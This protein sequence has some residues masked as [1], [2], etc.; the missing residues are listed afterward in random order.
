[1]GYNKLSGGELSHLEVMTLTEKFPD[2]TNGVINTHYLMA[3]LAMTIGGATGSLFD[4]IKTVE[5][6]GLLGPG[7]YSWGGMSATSVPTPLFG[8]RK[9]NPAFIN[10]DNLEKTE[11]ARLGI[12]LVIAGLIAGILPVA[13]TLGGGALAVAKVAPAVGAQSAT[14]ALQNAG[15]RNDIDDMLA[16]M[17]PPILPN[18]AKIELALLRFIMGMRDNDR[19]QLVKAVRQ[20]QSTP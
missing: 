1:M 14:R 3:S 6:P 9:W 4:L 11:F 10:M 8:A 17:A 20:M 15:L 18:Q 19:S 16:T 5:L 7:R 12:G 2:D 13:S